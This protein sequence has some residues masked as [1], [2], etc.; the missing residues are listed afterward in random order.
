MTDLFH[1]DFGFGVSILSSL[2]IVCTSELTKKQQFSAGRA[3]FSL[4]TQGEVASFV[5]PFPLNWAQLV[6]L[7]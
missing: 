7:S 3:V 6:S 4:L 2:V 1:S 5:I